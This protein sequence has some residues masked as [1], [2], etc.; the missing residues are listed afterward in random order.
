MSDLKVSRKLVEVFILKSEALINHYEA[1][2]QDKQVAYKAL[3]HQLGCAKARVYDLDTDLKVSRYEVRKLED[4]LEAAQQQQGISAH[5]EIVPQVSVQGP[6]R[7]AE[8]HC[9]FQELKELLELIPPTVNLEHAY[10]LE[11]QVLYTLFQLEYRERLDPY[12]FEATW[13]VACFYKLENL[14]TKIVVHAILELVYKLAAYI[15][16]K[17]FGLRRVLYYAK[18]ESELGQRRKLAASTYKGVHSYLI[19]GEFTWDI[20]LAIRF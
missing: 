8:F 17:D 2:L 20:G 10:A 5:E 19:G 1:L 14:L 3:E 15:R 4:E 9:S 18:L 6:K 7:E 16:I 13:Q 11:R 12:Q